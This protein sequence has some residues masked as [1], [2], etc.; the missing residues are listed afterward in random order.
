MGD[1]WS[2]GV[3]PGRVI[4]PRAPAD[5]LGQGPE[6][7]TLPMLPKPRAPSICL[8]SVIHSSCQDLGSAQD[9]ALRPRAAPVP[10]PT[11]PG[12]SPCLLVPVPSFFFKSHESKGIS[13]SS[14]QG[15]VGLV[16]RGQVGGKEREQ[17]LCDAWPPRTPHCG[18]S[19]PP[20]PQTSKLAHPS[21]ACHSG[22]QLTTHQLG[23]EPP[24]PGWW[25]SLPQPAPVYR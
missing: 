9:P 15:L 10:T 11:C 19:R 13:P 17:P 21:S 1:S 22:P 8:Q 25:A 24:G 23:G 3:P 2:K 16:F 18:L 12:A 4:L 7:E 6:P 5:S 20:R 14:R